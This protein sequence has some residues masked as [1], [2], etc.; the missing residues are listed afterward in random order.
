MI[1]RRLFGRKAATPAAGASSEPAGEPR[2]RSGLFEALFVQVQTAEHTRPAGGASFFYELLG[3]MSGEERAALL[4]SLAA[5]VDEMQ[6]YAGFGSASRSRYR[7][8]ALQFCQSLG[9][10]PEAAHLQPLAVLLC[11]A[12]HFQS[13]Y[14]TESATRMIAALNV[15]VAKGGHLTTEDCDMLNAYAQRMRGIA[16][17]RGRAEQRRLGTLADAVERLTGN[18]ISAASA[19]LERCEDAESPFAFGPLPPQLDFWTKVLAETADALDRLAADLR[20][21]RQPAWM[22]NADAFAASF[23]PAGPLAPR[24][25]QW[26]DASLATDTFD[27]RDFAQFRELLKLKQKIAS[28]DL[29]R[30]TRDRHARYVPMTRYRWNGAA[31]PQIERLGSLE[32]PDDTALLEHMILTK[33]GPRRPARWLKTALAI[34]ERQGLNVV[35]ARLQHWLEAFH[36]PLASDATI[37]EAWNC[38]VVIDAV[39]YLARQYPECPRASPPTRLRRWAPRWQWRSSAATRSNFRSNGC[40]CSIATR[41]ELRFSTLAAWVI[42]RAA[43]RATATISPRA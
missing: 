42:A 11:G 32:D 16:D 26:N 10:A 19:L 25:E 39:E 22:K 38:E 31:I 2:S 4:A 17:P 36:T 30:A 27:A 8:Q 35:Q 40:S 3:R 21:K 28:P 7:E 1:L 12:H 29:Y 9:F 18:T 6:T 43:E 13:R 14:S 5:D 33:E 15:A 37:A 24:F 41:P 20:G 23:P 34:A